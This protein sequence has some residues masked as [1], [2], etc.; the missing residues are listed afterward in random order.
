MAIMPIRTS[1]DN[2]LQFVIC[3][4]STKNPTHVGSV[5]SNRGIMSK[6]NMRCHTNYKQNTTWLRRNISV[7]CKLSVC[8]C[9]CGLALLASSRL[10]QLNAV[11]NLTGNCHP[12]LCHFAS[13]H[14]VVVM[15]ADSESPN[16]DEHDTYWDLKYLTWSKMTLNRHQAK[17][18]QHS[19]VL[20]SRTFV[21]TGTMVNF[22]LETEV[23]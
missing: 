17:R 5:H 12:T 3:F 6:T 22:P 8:A 18:A 11:R 9:T 19:T 15:T 16:H 4:Y 20:E 2:P 7:T 10:D 23:I 1:N 13:V 14:S 21:R